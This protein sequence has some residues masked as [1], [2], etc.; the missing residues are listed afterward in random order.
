[1]KLIRKRKPSM[2]TLLGVTNAKRNLLRQR[3]YQQ[4]NL[5]EKEKR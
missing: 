3:E 4:R 5:D 2:K 1:M